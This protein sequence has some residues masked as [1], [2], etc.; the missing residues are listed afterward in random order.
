MTDK[1]FPSD[2]AFTAAVKATQQRLGSRRA[3]QHMEEGAGWA[4]RLTQEVK[5]FVERQTSLFLATTNAEGQPYIQHRGGP[6]GFMRVLDDATLGFA[7]FRGNRQ[8]ITVGNL[9]ENPRVH[10]FLI[11]YAQQQRIKIWGKAR[12]VDDDAQLLTTLTM[13]D[14]RARVERALVIDI[15]AWDA[16]CPQ[17]IPRR[18]EAVDVEKALKSR[19]D[20]IAELEAEVARLKENVRLVESLRDR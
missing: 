6:P 16:N 14:Y 9:T 4:T 8:Y 3:Y 19:D 20:K 11:D 13:P 1:R 7:D 10:L 2:V 18:F 17:H 15:D 5:D 12:V